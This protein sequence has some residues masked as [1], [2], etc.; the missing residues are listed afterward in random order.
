MQTTW[1]VPFCVCEDTQWEDSLQIP[2]SSELLKIRNWQF[3]RHCLNRSQVVTDVGR[4]DT[5]VS[6]TLSGQFHT[7][8]KTKQTKNLLYIYHTLLFFAKIPKCW[9]IT[10]RNFKTQFLEPSQHCWP[11][12]S[13]GLK[14]TQLPVLLINPLLM[15]LPLCSSRT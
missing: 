5:L 6:F 3:L 12:N 11:V 1:T 15:T 13:C 7:P 10:Q 14:S 8:E 4:R 2:R 9:T